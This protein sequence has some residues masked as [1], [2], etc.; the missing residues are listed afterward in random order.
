MGGD[1]FWVRTTPQL[2]LVPLSINTVPLGLS[3]TKG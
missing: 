2:V 3:Q 1:L